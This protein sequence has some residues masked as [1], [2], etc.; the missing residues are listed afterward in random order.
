MGLRL[1][2]GR[3]GSGK[4]KYCFDEIAEE[5]N[6]NKIFVI[7]PEQFS[8]TAEKKLMNA[9]KTNAVFNAEVITFN[10]MAYRVMQDVGFANKTNLTKCGKAMLIYDVLNK[11]KNK[12]KFLGK[13]NENI[14][15][16]GK[17]ITEFKKHSITVEMLKDEV[18][19]Q[20]DEYLRLKLKDM[21]L[22]YEEFQNAIVQKYIDE[23]DT[24]TI[25]AEYIDQ[26]DLLKDSIIYIDEFA[27]FTT[28]EYEIIKKLLKIAKKVNV[29]ICMDDLD[30]A[31][32]PEKD[33]FY[34]NKITADKLINIAKQNNV[35]IDKSINLNK[36]YR[37]KNEELT[38]LENNIFAIPYKK[39]DKDVENISIFLANN[40]YTEIEYIA[41]NILKL[42][43]DEGYRY[44]N[45]AVIT[46]NIDTYSSLIKAI[47]NKYNI[48]V[49]IDEK[50]DLSQNL[51]VKYLISILDIFSKNWSYESVFNYLK[52]G[53]NDIEQEEIY[54]LENY[55]TKWGIT[56]NKWYKED[57]K[58]GAQNEEDVA[59][60]KRFNE[61]RRQIVEPL[62]NF[63]SKLVQNRTAKE[64]TKLLYEFL[65]QMNIENR[66]SEKIANLE[67]IGLIE[68]ANEYKSSFKNI[69]DVFDEIVLIFQDEKITFEKYTEIL[70][71]G[72]K[73]SGLGKIPATQDQVIIG[74]IDRSRSHKVRAIFLIGLN[75]G[76]FPSVNKNEGFFNDSDREK[77]K[78]NNIE[79]AKGTVE[80]IY[81]DN[82][83]I[84]KA[85]TTAEEKIYLSYSSLDSE[86]KTLRP[87]IF[88]SKIKKL[89]PCIVESSDDLE[90]NDDILNQE[91]T[92]DLLIQKINEFSE[93]KQIDDI[94]FVVYKYYENNSEWKDK[95]QKS[96][97]GI[98]YTNIPD[99]IEK[100]YTDKLY[101]DTLHTTI[102]RL[103][104]YRSCPFSF[105]LKYGLNLSEKE[106]F[107]IR[108]IDTGTFMHDVIDEFFEIIKNKNIDVKQVSDDYLD[109][110]VKNIIED[111]L[112]MDKNY[113]LNGT[114]KFR[115]LT[116]RLI[117]VVSLS[118]KYIIEGLRNTDFKVIGNEVE[119]K[120]GKAYPP[121][122]LELDDGKR[123]EITGKIDRIDLGKTVDGKYIRIIDYKS[124]VK[125]IDLNEVV[126]GI[127]LQLL[128]YLDAT[129][130]NDDVLPAGVLYFNLID[131][132]IK[133]NKPLTD[134]QI[135]Q[136]IKKK[137][138]MNGLILADINVVKMMDKKLENGASDS[139]PVYLD[140]EGNISN[141]KSSTVTKEQFN[142][143]QKYV[144]KTIKEISKELYDGNIDLKPYFNLKNKK[145]PCDYCEY[146]AVC[147]FDTSL[148]GNKYNYIGNLD[149]NLILDMI[150]E[151]K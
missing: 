72:L 54:K 143:L 78:E 6:E 40:Q 136:E 50:K 84:Y 45:I 108:N 114:S 35:K 121:I 148:C 8:F 102:S 12:L 37:Y 144:K 61:L 138:K 123:V 62:I 27:G 86:G 57:W 4:S 142:L 44:N 125:N 48:P 116:E 87:S 115:V 13:N 51:I 71:V 63:K 15:V 101:G 49:F 69:I 70:K 60:V 119:F 77:L 16:V 11:N 5:I 21:A 65:I 19:N 17:S 124:S 26:V 130:E 42:V 118:I 14:E 39:Y 83:N 76:M 36:I 75:D 68:L 82:F 104:Q 107:T 3:A 135:E 52:I 58:Y 47:F 94:W 18:E 85:F 149:K 103:E 126:S 46:K 137:F 95:L 64:L 147:Q 93:G 7:T 112:N 109:A 81:D 89:F 43:R 23:N 67:K 74:D 111:K 41:K 79:L 25:L 99:K 113:V 110:I 34:A 134:E 105:Y 53:L 145:T 90:E 106:T 73:N 151:S 2:Y 98:S 24:L 10:R 66:I 92:F 80:Q 1:I 38:H 29:T 31:S 133:A 33:I 28:Q 127:Q 146:K 88:I 131:P 30:S 141:S 91:T 9:I 139:V 140:K 132:I 20:K 55:C 150:K 117:K 100:V 120:T 59:Q 96:L 32:N 129:C 97:K 122:K 128:T 56:G 22:V